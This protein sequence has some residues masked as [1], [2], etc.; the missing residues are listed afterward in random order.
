MILLLKNLFFVIL[1]PGTFAVYVP[2]WIGLR[3]RASAPPPWGIQ[4]HVALLA[5]LAGAVICGW[6]VWHFAVT[7]K[8]TPAPI[9][10]PKRLVVIGPY[11]YVRN[12]MYLGVLAVLAG[13]AAYFN[14]AV[15]L[16]YGAAVGLCF[17]LFTT[18]VEERTLRR[19][20]GPSYE[21]YCSAVHRWI[22]GRRFDED[23]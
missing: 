12:P 9:D 2:L 14:S 20:F 10:A 6:S 21:A 3:H 15:L 19:K 22:P 5:L 7:G 23:E 17:H 16:G 1:V 13:W 8:G 11:R 4:Q 18:L